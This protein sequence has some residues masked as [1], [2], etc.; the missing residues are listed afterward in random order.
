MTSFKVGDT[1]DHPAYGRGAVEFVGVDKVGIAFDDGRHALLRTDQLQAD[2]DAAARAPSPPPQPDATPTWP[3]STFVKDTA[4]EKHAPGTHWRPFV[5][6][7]KDIFRR[8]PEWLPKMQVFR[9]HG[10]FFPPPHQVPADWPFGFMLCW[11]DVHGGMVGVCRTGKDANHLVAF[12]P[13]F[14]RGIETQVRLT[15][16]LVQDNGLEAQIEGAWG[17]APV[18]FYD[19]A[20]CINRG[21][22]EAGVDFDFILLGIAYQAR[23][24]ETASIPFTPNSD[25][26]AWEAV[27]AAKHGESVQPIPSMLNLTGMAMLIP[28]HGWD[29]DE[30]QFRGPVRE[31]TEV[32]DILG[33]PA[34]RLI[35]T[36]L[37]FG[38]EDANL[39]ILVTRRAWKAPSPPTVGMDI[40]GALW[41]QGRLWGPSSECVLRTTKS[42]ETPP[43]SPPH[44]AE[45]KTAAAGSPASEPPEP[46]KSESETAKNPLPMTPPSDPIELNAEQLRHFAA[47][48]NALR[49]VRESLDTDTPL[50]PM[51]WNTTVFHERASVLMGDFVD[52]AVHFSDLIEGPFQRVIADNAADEAPIHRVAGRLLEALENV[53]RLRQE[54]AR[55]PAA[56]SE[57]Q[58]RQLIVGAIDH[59]LGEI[60]TWLDELVD[61][62]A[63]PIG[64]LHKRGLPSDGSAEL[65]LKCTLT[66]APQVEQ[67][68]RW[69][70]QRVRE[71]AG[72]AIQ[73]AAP[74]RG[75]FWSALLTFCAGAW[76]VDCLFGRKDP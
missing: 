63:D 44:D 38:D 49:P 17:D 74:K 39:A 47:V 48:S 37:R 1:I 24:S 14:E 19:V 6:D 57:V 20:Y 28:M 11:P 16:V 35:V 56:G 26:V 42:G 54:A 40:E 22:Y 2:L 3:D 70:E 8:L 46:A 67:F 62:F 33:E 60:R 29:E 43:A 10:T 18:T 45:A 41:L 72:D 53:R 27:I 36:V 69:A 13:Y 25:Q 55:M 51:R 50:P 73:R 76:L 75:G 12:C 34:W 5:D 32:A 58:G 21:W 59:T 9:A 61:A 68:T 7:A 4:P 71:L 23:P 66:A 30:Y 31:I 15:R 65:L 64:S 52:A